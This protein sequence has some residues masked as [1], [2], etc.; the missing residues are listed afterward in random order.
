MSRVAALLIAFWAGS[1]STVCG[2]VAPTL[3][4]VLDDRHLAGQ[5]AARFFQI[6]AWIGVGIGAL[7][8][9]L[10]A[11]GKLALP[12]TALIVVTA[13]LP[14][15]SELLLGPLM[16]QAREAGNMARVGVFH[17]VAAA[18]FLVACVG[19]L[20]LVWQFNRRAG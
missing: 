5:L 3:F 6:E 2:I 7:L 13:G 8:I 11:L 18:C 20:S 15:A 19:A 9:A 12:A 4:S 17:G 16:H 10:K 14:L 1:L